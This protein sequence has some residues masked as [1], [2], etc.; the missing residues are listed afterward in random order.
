MKDAEKVR[1]TLR[2]FKI[3]HLSEDEAIDY[4]DRHYSTS[5]IIHLNVGMAIGVV[6]A[7]ISFFLA[8]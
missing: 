6:I 8:T 5:K 4:I 2:V 3:E 7:I 1:L